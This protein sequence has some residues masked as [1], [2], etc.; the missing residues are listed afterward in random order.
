MAVTDY[1]RRFLAKMLRNDVPLSRI[2]L[3]IQENCD[4]KDTDTFR[5]ALADFVDRP[6][7]PVS[8]EQDSHGVYYA[9]SSHCALSDKLVS[10]ELL[11]QV[12]CATYE[13]WSL[14]TRLTPECRP[15]YNSVN[16]K[17]AIGGRHGRP[18]VSRHSQAQVR[19][20]GR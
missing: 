15:C 1:N 7:V 18:G 19:H 13:P 12:R 5:D 10:L 2:A 8:F 14:N 6:T 17:E 11:S 9:I 16:K 4:G 3:F 20:V